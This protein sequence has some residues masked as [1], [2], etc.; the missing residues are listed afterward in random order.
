M[1]AKDCLFPIQERHTSNHERILQRLETLACPN[2]QVCGLI[3]LG[4]NT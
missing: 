3:H 4:K 2:L 1:P